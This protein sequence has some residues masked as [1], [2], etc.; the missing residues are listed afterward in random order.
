[1][2]FSEKNYQHRTLRYCAI[3]LKVTG[4]PISSTT[5]LHSIV[6]NFK[7]QFFVKSS[8]IQHKGHT[9]PGLGCSH[10][11]AQLPTV[12]RVKICDDRTLPG[13]VISLLTQIADSSDACSLSS[14][15]MGCHRFR[16]KTVH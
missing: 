1:M 6:H 4:L 2:S 15:M 13:S 8:N 3:D 12:L 7:I 11:A 14:N 16:S 10:L 9:S 5:F